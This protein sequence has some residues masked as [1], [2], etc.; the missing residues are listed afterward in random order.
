MGNKESQ[1]RTASSI[2]RCRGKR[3]T[4]QDRTTGSDNSSVVLETKRDTSQRDD[5]RK[6]TDAHAGEHQA[7]NFSGTV[8]GYDDTLVEQTRIVSDVFVAVHGESTTDAFPRR[9]GSHSSLRSLRKDLLPTP[10]RTDNGGGVLD[11]LARSSE[12]IGNPTIR[13]GSTSDETSQSESGCVSS[14]ISESSDD[15]GHRTSHRN[16]SSSTAISD[17]DRGD[18]IFQWSKNFRH[19]SNRGGGS[20]CDGKLL[21][22]HDPSREDDDRFEAVHTLDA[23]ESVSDGNADRSSSE[24]DEVR[25][26]LPLL[27][28]QLGRGAIKSS[29]HHPRYD[30]QRQRSTRTS[31]LSS[32]RF[33][34]DGA[35]RFLPRHHPQL[36]TPLRQ[37]NAHEVPELGSTFNTSSARDDRSERRYHNEAEHQHR[38]SESDE[39]DF[40]EIDRMID[41]SDHE[42]PEPSSLRFRLFA[43]RPTQVADRN[44]ASLP[45]H[46]Q[47]P[48]LPFLSWHIA[49]QIMKTAASDGDE[50]VWFATTSAYR[51]E[52][53]AKEI[54]D[55]IPTTE[56]DDRDALLFGNDLEELLRSKFAIDTKSSV[57]EF[58]LVQ[59]DFQ[60]ARLFGVVETRS[61][62]DRRRI[63]S[64]PEIMNQGEHQII[65]QLK[66][67]HAIVVFNKAS[68]VRDRGA[69]MKFA[70]SLDFKKFFQQFELLV[71]RFWPFRFQRRVFFLSSVPTGA[72][73][74]PLFAQ[75]LSRTLLALAVRIA[76]SESTVEH[77][78]CIDN[79]RLCSDDLPA[80]WKSWREL[81]SLCEAL[82]A[83]IGESN[84]PPPAAP[85]PYTY[86][87]M[88]FSVVDGNSIVELALKSKKKVQKAIEVISSGVELLAVDAIA[89]FGQT[90]WATTVT[91]YPLGKLYH[92][93]K[94]IRRIQRKNM[95]DMIRIWPSIVDQWCRALSEMLSMKFKSMPPTN[96]TATMFTDASESG[97]GVVI[98]DF[99]PQ[100]IRIFA[101]KWTPKE[102]TYSINLLELR[103]LRIGIRILASIKDDLQSVDLK[104]FIDNTSARAWAIRLRA[105]KWSANEIATNI[106]DLTRSSSIQLSSI[107][108]VESA[109]NLADAP[110][111][112][113]ESTCV[114]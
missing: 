84:P 52:T 95:T 83:T 55:M 29:S 68:D 50:Q 41:R 10:T 25:Q 23:Q 73:F 85:Y 39:S 113:Y 92:V 79:L 101:G 59:K 77:D 105:P 107:D 72:V 56:R 70:A 109:R 37:S 112:K 65:E 42:V 30:H 75:A 62:Q 35:K 49:D 111:R 89:L 28:V 13:C 9:C 51:D 36:L 91:G 18:S 27:G 78:S 4:T 21:D 76:N 46:V 16:I 12:G 104:V 100:P 38:R 6:E 94:F 98:L 66:S 63:I 3:F 11:H 106:G 19:D 17:S 15:D 86:L 64:W 97:W 2:R 53:K 80:L 22:D 81:I 33:A 88:L 108:Y 54:F 103:A 48:P 47:F 69:R 58:E 26:A 60:Y 40:K 57:D 7:I 114:R 110:S 90:V 32:R 45:L 87:G 5:C 96:S 67:K 8:K 34:T 61:E 20:R 102:Q 31:K 93:L 71:K 82:G 24:C 44:S 43:K 1:V 99:D 74:P 14:S